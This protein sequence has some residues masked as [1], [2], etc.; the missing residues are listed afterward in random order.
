MTAVL[1]AGADAAAAQLAAA[2][3]WQVPGFGPGPIDVVR[4]R[5]TTG[6]GDG[7]RPRLLLRT[8]SPR[9]GAYR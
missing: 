1:H 8:T 2:W 7:H 4:N 3:L 9:C 6:A 5:A